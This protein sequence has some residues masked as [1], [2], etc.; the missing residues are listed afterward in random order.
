MLMLSW[1][2]KYKNDYLQ[3]KILEF[4][5]AY[6]GIAILNFHNEEKIESIP[7]ERF[8][9]DN[10]EYNMISIRMLSQKENT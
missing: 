2:H 1:K 10:E 4:K 5:D 7:N 9:I 3:Y 6:S 8:S